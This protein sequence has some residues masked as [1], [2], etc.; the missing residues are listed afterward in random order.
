M[1]HKC[2]IKAIYA[3]EKTTDF[4]KIFIHFEPAKTP[5]QTM[6]GAIL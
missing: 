4:N 2:N 3:K 6:F 5:L 1:T